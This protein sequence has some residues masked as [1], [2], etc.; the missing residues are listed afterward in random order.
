MGYLL[1]PFFYLPQNVFSFEDVSIINRTFDISINTHKMKNILLLFLSFLLTNSML[2]A[3]NGDTIVV[4]TIDY[5]TPVLS[6]WN[7]PRSGMYLFPADTISFS[8]VLMSYNLKC[9]PDQ[10]PACGEW[11]YTT[12]TKI[13]EH[14]GVYDSNLYYHANYLVNNQ[15]PDSFMMMQSPSYSYNAILEYFNQTIPSNVAEP[16]DGTQEMTIP[17]NETSIDGRSQ[18]IYTLAELQNAGLQSGDITGLTFN[19]LSG[20]VDLKHFTVRLSHTSVD[21]LPTDS[22]ISAGLQT[23]YSRNTTL[24]SSNSSIYFA[25]PFSW[26]GSQ[27]ILIDISYENHTGSA[28]IQADISGSNQS[29]SSS[30][31]DYSLN[32]EGWD[33]IN[34]PKEAFSTID[35]AITISFWQYGNPDIQP[36]NSS[37][38][39]AVD[40]LGNR[41]LNAHLPWSN[42][43]VYWDAGYDGYDRI[44]GQAS[45]QE[46]EGKWNFWTFIKDTKS[47]YMQILLNGNLWFIG[48][49]KT[50]LMNNIVEFKI[51]GAITYDGYYS[52]MIDDFRIW[53]T[54]LSWSDVAEWMYKDIDETHPMYSHLR[55]YYKFNAGIGYEAVDSSPNNFTGTQFGYPE[56]TS[57]KG[58]SRFRNPLPVSTRPHLQIENGNYNAA[59]LDSIVVIDTIEQTAVNMLLFDPLNPPQAS[60]TLTIWQSYYNNYIYD[61]GGI[62]IDSTFVTPDDIIYHEDYPYYGTPFEILVPWEI[63]RFITPYGNNLS[64]GDDGFTWVYDVTDYISLL[65]DS[66]H[67][68]AGNFQE[69]LDLEFYMIEGTPPRDLLKLEKVYSGYWYLEN[70]VEDVPPDTIALLADAHTYKVRTRTSGH[71]FDNPTNCAE[72]CAKIQSLEVDGELVEEWQILQECSDNPLY[73][74]GGTWIYDRAGWCPGMKVTEQDIEITPFIT[75]DTVVIDYNTQYDQYGTYSLEVHLFSFGLPNFTLDASVDEIITPNNLKRYARV[76]PSASAPIIKISN[77]G[78][79]TLTSLD[80]TYGP[81]GHETTY[82]WTGNLAFT[83]QEEVTLEAFVWEDWQDGDGNFSVQ[84]SNPNGGT[85]ENSI[86]DSYYSNYDLPSVYPNTIV[87]HFR[88]NKAGYQNNYQILTNDGELIFEKDGFENET[89]YVDTVT[90]I[91][92][93][94]DFYLWD[95]EDN[96]ISFWANNQ[97]S[98][99]IKFMDIEGN[100]IQYFGGDFGDHIY[101]SF[102]SDMFLGT[103]LHDAD[104]STFDIIPNPNDGDFIVSYALDKKSDIRLIIYNSSGQIIKEIEKAGLTND[105][106]KV[107]LMGIP[108]GVYT[109][110]L[111]TAN[112]TMNK[113]FVITK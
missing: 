54:I 39:E 96:G 64:L 97:G 59:L 55:A 6:G 26:D 67:I 102:Y 90:L 38:F 25:F 12:Q 106:I 79:E 65:R 3:D 9:D 56:W 48:S 51:G 31:P 103:S 24:N 30:Q 32:F 63:G 11:D 21:I 58:T 108:A 86:N 16:G 61:E 60:D 17:F 100:T 105:K 68:T 87:I 43:K 113:K 28:I 93:C 81:A 23:V 52:G 69:L 76:N 40:S 70:F 47:S 22:I 20:S 95:S 92:G 84:L 34:V 94:Y 37:I 77:L 80:I 44:V 50:K 45:P 57:Y 75:G 98:G 46:Y 101:K 88:T 41:V 72:F 74:Q 109:C 29:I 27:N 111:K 62:A 49:G 82:N 4:Q 36:T 73:P 99:Y 107:S 78:S 89:L 53:D 10:S 35:S 1:S 18:Y 42:G 33:L 14:T 2:F 5:D 85:D 19:I 71:L 13:W 112:N 7:S 8:K 110:L 83:E 91:N 66:V 104:K 15:S